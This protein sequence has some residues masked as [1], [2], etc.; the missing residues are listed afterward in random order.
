MIHQYTFND[1]TASDSV[2]GSEWAGILA[3]GATVVGGQAQFPTSGPY[4]QLP[5]G[6]LG[7]SAS[8]TIEGWVN[9]SSANT[10][11]WP[12]IFDFGTA[13][14]VNNIALSGDGCTGNLYA[15]L[16]CGG[17]CSSYREYA[18]DIPFSSLGYAYFAVVLSNGGSLL[19]YV[20][21]KLV[22]ESPYAVT[23]PTVEQ[24]V[25]IL[26]SP[27]VDRHYNVYLALTSNKVRRHTFDF[28]TLPNH[29]LPVDVSCLQVYFYIGK[30]LG[31]DVG[32]IGSVDEI[33]I[34][35]GALDDVTIL[36]HYNSGGKHWL[37]V[38]HNLL[39]C[40]HCLPQMHVSILMLINNSLSFP[41]TLSLAITLC[42]NFSLTLTVITNL[43]FILIS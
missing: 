33:R 18:T 35:S 31:G 2:G 26:V 3:D 13:C 24:Q 16:Q 14:G 20:N 12:R 23:I 40:L 1:G 34:W 39:L 17:N 9:V 27:Q 28:H 25:C 42:F 11:G 41:V 22:W 10:A 15:G 8:V 32:L 21:G 4:V 30:S 7:A 19:L 37:S 6:V 36:A 43:A 38:S 5:A 29:M